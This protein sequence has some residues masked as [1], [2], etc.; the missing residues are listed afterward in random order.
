MTLHKYA[1]NATDKVL[2]ALGLDLNIASREDVSRAIQSVIVQAVLEAEQHHTKATQD[3]CAPED[4]DLAHKLAAEIKRRSKA[5][6]TNLHSL[7]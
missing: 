3:V 7:R 2:Q 6:V 5:L 4:Q 1:E